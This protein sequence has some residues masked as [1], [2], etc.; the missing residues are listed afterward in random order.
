MN[1]Q[2]GYIL[3]LSRRYDEA[4]IQ[5]RK[6]IEMD[7]N[8]PLAHSDLGNVY[9]LKGM[10]SEAIAE[11]QKAADLN[12]RPPGVMLALA[13]VYAISGQEKEARRIRA[14]L[15]E[16]F[17]MGR[18]G[19]LYMAVLDLALNEHDRAISRLEQACATHMIE[20]LTPTPLFDPLRADARIV[21]AL[22][23]PESR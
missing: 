19:A 16:P 13:H 23:C 3:F 20:P 12:N 17:R 21:D 10:Y 22:R 15:E 18:L 6:A 8:F 2:V 7:P 9:Q 11:L 1:V 5:L 4:A 14:T